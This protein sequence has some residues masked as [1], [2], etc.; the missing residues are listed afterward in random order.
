MIE[1]ATIAKNEIPVRYTDRAE[2]GEFLTIDCPNGWDDVKKICKKVLSYKGERYVFTGWNSDR[3][4]C[5]F[6]KSKEVAKI[7]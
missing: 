3:N 5:Y 7:I 4:D 1:T 6:K 2:Y